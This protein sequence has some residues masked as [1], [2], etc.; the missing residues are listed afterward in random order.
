[1][2]DYDVYAS[3][4]FNV[5]M[6]ISALVDTDVTGARELTQLDLSCKISDKVL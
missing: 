2:H 5:Q 1:M 6:T 3:V 4:N